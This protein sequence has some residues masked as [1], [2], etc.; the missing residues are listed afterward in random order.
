MRF[1]SHTNIIFVK[2]NHS[3]ADDV[4]QD[5]TASFI[6]CELD[7]RPPPKDTQGGIGVDKIKPFADNYNLWFRLFWEPRSSLENE[8]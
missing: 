6:R 1:M 7:L 5:Q 8:R 4:E 2:D 3:V